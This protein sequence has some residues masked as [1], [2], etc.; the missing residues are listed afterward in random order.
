MREVPNILRRGFNS[1]EVGAKKME[2]QIV[3]RSGIKGCVEHLECGVELEDI[4]DKE[5]V[6]VGM[7]P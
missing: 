3:E 1:D 7:N 6:L 4:G 5:K 2:R